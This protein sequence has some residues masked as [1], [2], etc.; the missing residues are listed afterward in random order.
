MPVDA[1]N[2]GS[3]V[4]ELI[5]IRTPPEWRD[6]IL[7]RDY[8]DFISGMVNTKPPFDQATHPAST[9]DPLSGENYKKDYTTTRGYDP[10][11]MNR[12][13]KYLKSIPTLTVRDPLDIFNEDKASACIDSDDLYAPECPDNTVLRS[14]YCSQVPL[15]VENK[16][17]SI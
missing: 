9:Y 2:N 15:T 5:D 12:W 3:F 16:C 11:A 7:N 1:N 14:S 6:N 4:Q 10:V 17:L 13:K 8:S